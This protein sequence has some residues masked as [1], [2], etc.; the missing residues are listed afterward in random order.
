MPKLS[1]TELN[2]IRE[3]V[4]CHQTTAA[5]LSDYANQITDP[6]IKQMFTKAAQEARNA[7]NN[8]ISMI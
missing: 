1:Q 2:S 7:A 5:K 8:L 3:V 6:Q 4:A